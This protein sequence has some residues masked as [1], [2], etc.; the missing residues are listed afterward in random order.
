MQALLTRL[1]TATGFVEI[2]RRVI[3]PAKVEPL[4]APTLRL[5]ERPEPYQDTPSGLPVV[6][7]MYVDAVIYFINKDVSIAGMTILNPL[8]D[9]VDDVLAGADN[10]STNVLTLGGLVQWCRIV[11]GEIIKESGDTDTQGLGG[12]I[13]P[14]AMQLDPP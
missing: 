8:I 11:K 12:A 1:S 10:P 2:S 14:I 4:R 5:W 6:H 9:A 7:T 3:L 13:I